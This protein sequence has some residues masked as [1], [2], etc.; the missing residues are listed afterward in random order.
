MTCSCLKK[1]I[2]LAIILV[3]II[4]GY[5]IMTNVNEDFVVYNRWNGRPRYRR[6]LYRPW[7]YYDYVSPR[8]WYYYWRPP[9]D[10]SQVSP[11][12]DNIR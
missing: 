1:Y 10:Y 11:L 12:I 4:I 7:R 9:Y 8:S 3:A 6:H 5:N 2:V